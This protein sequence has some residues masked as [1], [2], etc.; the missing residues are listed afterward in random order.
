MP[1]ASPE[2]EHQKTLLIHMLAEGHV[3]GDADKVHIAILGLRSLGYDTA[4]IRA[5]LP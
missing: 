2:Q 3:D 4:G 1:T 5:L